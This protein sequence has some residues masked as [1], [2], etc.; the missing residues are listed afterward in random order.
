MRS[1]LTLAFAA[2]AA[3]FVVDAVPLDERAY[4]IAPQ[5]PPGFA[6]QRIW[7]DKVLPYCFSNADARTRLSDNVNKA[8]DRWRNA[9]GGLGGISFVE[10]ICNVN[11]KPYLEISAVNSG[12]STT[13]AFHGP[14]ADHT[15][16]INPDGDYDIGIVGS[17]T[18]EIGHA[19][20][21]EHEHQRESAV[22]LIR[23]A[24]TADH[25]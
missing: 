5:E 21:L 13:L 19:L 23:Q 25:E 16:Q 2:L 1:R 14:N 24:T 6:F 20:G 10:V 15:L 12:A 9:P 17:L 11:N 7:P 18:H 4:S 8:L 3:T 22:L